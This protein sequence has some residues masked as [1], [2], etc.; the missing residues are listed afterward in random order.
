MF[1]FGREHE[2]KCAVHYVRDP[3]QAELISMVVDSIHDYLDGKKKG[4]RS[5]RSG[6]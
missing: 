5:R 3:S 2:R 6:V 1:T 4:N